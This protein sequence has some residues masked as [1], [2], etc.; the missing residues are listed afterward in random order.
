MKNLFSRKLLAG[1]AVLFGLSSVAFALTVP[2]SISVR[3]VPFQTNTHYR[4]T[5]NFN[6]G[7]I[8]NGIKIGAIPAGAFIESVKCHVLTVFNA[9][10]LNYLGIG[11]T[12]AITATG[13]GDW[14]HGATGTTASCVLA[15]LGYQNLSTAVALGLG[16]TSPAT[17]TGTSG[18][19]D[20][21]VRYY[22]TGTAATTGKATVIM[23]YVANDDM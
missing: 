11:T 5:V 16:T 21:W 23:N 20:V 10:T 14:V 19:W 12:Q 8:G 18:G 3:Q 9:G 2:P 6:D 13:A 4:F 17:T 1:L 22:Q 15:T 7:N